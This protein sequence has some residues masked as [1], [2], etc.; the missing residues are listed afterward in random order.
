MILTK[1]D[2]FRTTFCLY[3]MCIKDIKRWKFVCVGVECIAFNVLMH[4][5]SEQKVIGNCF[6]APLNFKNPLKT[7]FSIR[8]IHLQFV[9]GV[10]G[11]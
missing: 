10:F 8:N 7:G 2:Y 11:L 3:L 6:C 9:L 4:T 5:K 1:K